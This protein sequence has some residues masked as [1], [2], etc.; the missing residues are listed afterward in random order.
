MTRAA[1]A[2]GARYVD[3]YYS[4]AYE[5]RV[6][7]DV[8][9]DAT[10]GWTPPWLLQ[11]A[12]EAVARGGA[13]LAIVGEPEPELFAGLDPERVARGRM[14][15]LR[16]LYGRQAAQRALNVSIIPRGDHGMGACDVRRA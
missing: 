11:R 7:I 6:H 5:R 12:E 2:A 14:R 10:L 13:G 9:P 3:L 4:D 16:R 1:Y 8:A 15:E